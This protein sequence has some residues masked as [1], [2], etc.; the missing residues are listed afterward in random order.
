VGGRAPPK[1]RGLA[2]SHPKPSFFIF[3]LKNNNKI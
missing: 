3:V 2:A 1:S